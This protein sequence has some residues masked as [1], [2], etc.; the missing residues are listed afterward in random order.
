MKIKV[1]DLLEPR[2]IN[3]AGD[4][5]WLSE[6][7]KNFGELTSKPSE[8]RITGNLQ[9]E[10]PQ[11]EQ[12]AVSGK[13]FFS[14]SLDCARCSDP[15]TWP[16]A[17][18]LEAVFRPA[19]EDVH[20]SLVDLQ[21]DALADYFIDEA[22]NIDIEAFL[23]DAIMT[24]VPSQVIRKDPKTQQCMICGK[25]LGESLVYSSHDLSEQSPFAVLKDFKTK[26]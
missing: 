3:I 15:I 16:I 22:G 17:L 11:Y 13:I 20:E 21:R 23:N 1:T 8:S 14:P 19:S 4:E 26:H 24:E 6:I 12:V 5:P 25:D 10:P 9:I 18:D 2:S 7:Y